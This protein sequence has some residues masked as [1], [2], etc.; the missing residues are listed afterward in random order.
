MVPVDR[1]VKSGRFGAVGTAGAGPR[2]RPSTSPSSRA[3]C[4]GPASTAGPSPR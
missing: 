3:S 1:A 4:W 2:A